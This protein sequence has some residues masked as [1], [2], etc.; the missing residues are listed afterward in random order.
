LFIAGG[1]AAGAAV[2]VYLLLP[3]LRFFFQTGRPI[4]LVFAVQQAWVA[5]VFLARRPPRSVSRRMIDW[6]A[7]FAGSF[8]FFLVRP[9][10]YHPAWGVT[11]GLAVQLAGLALW[12]WAFAKLAGCYGIVAADRGLVTGGPYA[13]VRHPLYAAYMV[14]GIGYLI[15]SLSVW[16]AVVDLV[17]VGC[18]L[19]RVKAEERHLAGPAYDEYRERVRWRLW[20]GIW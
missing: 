4:G 11:T 7:A 12:A 10:G 20:P 5:V 18:Q 6:V 13:I 3:N 14:G 8:S 19:L 16:N 17:A 2:A 15:Q 1:N 9:G